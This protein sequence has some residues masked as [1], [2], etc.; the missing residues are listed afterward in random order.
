MLMTSVAACNDDESDD[1]IPAAYGE[2]DND[3]EGDKNDHDDDLKGP[4]ADGPSP[5]VASPPPVQLKHLRCQ[6]IKLPLLP[7]S[8][9][10]KL[11]RKNHSTFEDSSQCQCHLPPQGKGKYQHLRPQSKGNMPAF[12][13]TE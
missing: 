8:K 2:G 3:D 1:G 4:Q 12:A 9:H 13:A 10:G 11:R 7:N 6:T 5:L